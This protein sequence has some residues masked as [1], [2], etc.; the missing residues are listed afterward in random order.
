MS[1]YQK[2]DIDKTFSNYE[3]YDN[4]IY[5]SVDEGIS[6]FT[7]YG[8]LENIK[9]YNN[10]VKSINT[11]SIGIVTL[12]SVE[13]VK[14]NES[15]SNVYINNNDLYE[16]GI[17]LSQGIKDIYIHENRIYRETSNNNLNY[18]IYMEE[19][20]KRICPTNII[21]KNN[22][23]KA[24]DISCSGI[25]VFLCDN[26][27]VDSNSFDGLSEGIRFSASNN[28]LGMLIS[29]NLFT[30][31]VTGVLSEHTRIV[32]DSNTFITCE[33]SILLKS[34]GSDRAL[35]KNN[36]FKLSNEGIRVLAKITSRNLTINSNYF[37]SSKNY[38]IIIDKDT[39]AD[40]SS[41]AL[42]KDNIIEG[43]NSKLITDETSDIKRYFIL[44]S[45]LFFSK[46]AWTWKECEK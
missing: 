40:F 19:A 46:E 38:N 14:F 2:D 8:R 24:K 6:I 32:I 22:D 1:S 27:V 29:N 31:C 16:G 4:N 34:F 45:N 44:F 33:T 10:V 21:I 15:I 7:Y 23:L 11:S 37:S 35:I 3:I 30:N 39:T 43:E 12:S 18:L 13:S 36:N 9:I 28:Q 26:M 20:S 25:N 41:R 5:A 42:I 17:F